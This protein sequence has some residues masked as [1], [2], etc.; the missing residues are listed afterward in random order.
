[1]ASIIISKVSAET[2]YNSLQET[3]E[4]DREEEARQQHRKEIAELKEKWKMYAS[5]GKR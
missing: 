4:G 2:K 3:E 1:M 5:P